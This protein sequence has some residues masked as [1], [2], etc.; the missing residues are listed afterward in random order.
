MG[1]RARKAHIRL[2]PLAVAMAAMGE[3][4]LL[5]Y[6]NEHAGVQG[7]QHGCWPPPAFGRIQLFRFAERERDVEKKVGVE[8]TITSKPH[9]GSRLGGSTA[10][11]SL[12]V[13]KSSGLT[14][15]LKT[16]ASLLTLLDGPYPN[17]STSAV[18]KTDRLILIAG[19]IGITAVL[20]FI[21]HH[22]NVKLYWSVKENAK[23]LVADLDG[24]L[25]NL[26][27]KQV[28]VGRRIDVGAV[29]DSEASTGW[30]RIGVVVCGPGGLCDDVRASVVSKSRAG[31]TVWELD[32][33]AFTW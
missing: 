9:G 32:V 10:G 27:E 15:A 17:T 26:R 31:K 29:L 30:E 24:A 33:E 3:S 18:L 22:P 25:R 8:T 11:I 7:P 2:L 4:P 1:R 16:H 13:R 23:G 19:G 20:P 6:P 14:R 5:R 28:D 21:A 12:Y